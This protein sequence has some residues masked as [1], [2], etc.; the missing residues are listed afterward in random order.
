[1]DEPNDELSITV[2]LWP[3]ETFF[4]GDIDF[5]EEAA[6]HPIIH[7]CSEAEYHRIKAFGSSYLKNIVYTSPQH[8]HVPIDGGDS[9]TM[10]I[11]FE[12]LAQDAFSATRPAKLN[13]QIAQGTFHTH[14]STFNKRC[15]LRGDFSKGKNIK[16]I[17]EA[18]YEENKDK[19]HVTMP[20]LLKAMEMV[21]SSLGNDGWHRHLRGGEW[22]QVI[23]WMEQGL[24]MK[25]ML[26][27]NYTSLPGQVPV[28]IKT[29]NGKQTKANFDG[30]SRQTGKLMYDLQAA[31]YSTGLA[32]IY[33][34]DK[35]EPFIFLVIEANPPYGSAVYKAS[36]A[37][38][39][40]GFALRDQA[41]K[42]LQE[43][44]NEFPAGIEPYA[45]Y[46]ENDFLLDPP[47]YH[48]QKATNGDANE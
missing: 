9:F 31:H 13:Q 22:Q 19:T 12:C 43:Y 30:F 44:I 38:N 28:D 34:H 2:D 18:W 1:M 40:S 32:Q 37:F 25:A 8:A 6:D 41:I 26:D 42:R 46:N 36:A 4:T 20:N 10:G 16:A 47:G 27:F 14:S 24:P 45:K 48:W 5:P 15:A 39:E 11:A 21:K 3:H 29:C 23:L 35:V 7:D 33:G 17:R